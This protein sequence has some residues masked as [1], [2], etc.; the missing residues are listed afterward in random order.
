MSLLELSK[1][2]STMC[3]LSRPDVVATLEALTVMLLGFITNGHI[4]ELGGLGTL[5]PQI[6]SKPSTAAHE[7]SNDISATQRP[8][9]G[10]EKK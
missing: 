7:V 1:E 6:S 8:S 5:G 9:T 4:V 10:Q 2:I 3:S